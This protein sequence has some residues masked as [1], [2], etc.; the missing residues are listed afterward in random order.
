[1]NPLRPARS[2]A[3]LWRAAFLPVL[4]ALLGLPAVSHGAEQQQKY[5]IPADT[6]AR[7]LKLFS[8]QSGR[9]LIADGELLRGV[10]TNAVQGEMTPRQAVDQLLAGTNLMASADPRT[11]DFAIKRIAPPHVPRP[12]PAPAESDAAK[13]AEVLQLSPFV[14]SEDDATG[15]SANSTLAGTRLNTA[16]RDVGASISIITAEFLIDTASTNLGELLSFTTGTEVGGAFG[17]FAGG[18]E[19]FGRPDQSEAREN[20]DSNQRVRGIGPASTTRDFFLSDIPMDA[21]NTSRVTINRGPNS[22]LFG[23]GNPAGT[24]DTSLSKAQVGR[25]R[26]QLTA[27]YGSNNSYRGT[28]DVNRVLV[29]DRLA[30]RVATVGEQNNFDQEPAFDR[31]RRIYG[32]VEAVLRKGQKSSIVGKT[33]FRASGEAGDSQSTPVNVIPPTDAFSIFFQPPDPAIDSLPGINLHPTV[34]PGNPGYLWAPRVTVDNRSSS[35]GI[36]QNNGAYYFVPW[37]IHI[38]LVFDTPGQRTPGYLN[39]NNPALQ[40]FRP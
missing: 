12:A 24:I 4:A 33:I 30:L 2:L 27:R 31:K 8:E 39:G 28:L 17:N 10:R 7:A 37:F 14:V 15:Y 16:L 40:P 13:D 1:M 6:A 3:R 18:S 34:L 36:L 29:K 35:T 11:G 38:P 22:L 20:P 23:I 5:S 26:T 21:Y 9:T 25:N 32:A 19:S